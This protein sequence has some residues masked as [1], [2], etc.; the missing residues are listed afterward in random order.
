MYN[1]L[2]KYLYMQVLRAWDTKSNPKGHEEI[3]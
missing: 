3:T 1:L 2:L